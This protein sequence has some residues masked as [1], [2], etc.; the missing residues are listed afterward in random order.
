MAI[1]TT[2]TW[3]FNLNSLAI[4]DDT[5][6][7]RNA[8]YARRS[9]LLGIKDALTG[10]GAQ[11]WTV[12]D[13][14][15]S[16]AAPVGTDTWIV[17]DDLEWRD[18]DTA[19]VFSW[20]VLR[21]T[22]ISTTFEILLTCEQDINSHDGASIGAWV[23]QAGFSG[24]ST[25]VRPTATDERRLRNSTGEYWGSGNTSSSNNY[26]YHVM[27]SSDGQCTRVLIF[28]NDVNTGFWLFDKPA[29]PLSGWTDPYI[30]TISGDN[31]I[32][33]NQCSY[34]K[35]HDAAGARGRY[36]GVDTTIYLSGEGFGTNASGE[37]FTLSGN[38][39]D[40]SLIA[41]EM[42]VSSLTSTFAGRNGE[43]F[44]LWWGLANA[45]TGRNYPNTSTKTYVQVQHMIFPWD[46][47]TLIGTK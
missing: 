45:G 3:Q 44:D 39:I 46:G 10:F 2:K 47:S 14:T 21:Q 16:T 32:T 30:A 20:I 27:Q 1:I 11:P 7:G 4:I 9:L 43:V 36:N 28:I 19:S 17:P 41:N 42:G 6:N 22:G 5:L 38:Q 26:R 12:T 25:T 8:H 15:N 40:G 34:S 35:F 18:D 29:N 31:N 33:T 23:A 37:N 13:S 24:G